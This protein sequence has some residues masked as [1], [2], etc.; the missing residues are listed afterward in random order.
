MLP[1]LKIFAAAVDA[2]PRRGGLTVLRR[3][4]AYPA[5]GDDVHDQASIGPAAEPTPPPADPP[6]EEAPLRRRSLEHLAAGLA[7]A[8]AERERSRRQ[9][10]LHRV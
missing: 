1:A 4:D 5:G 3:E 10:R 8:Y 6:E 7:R 2:A 9:G